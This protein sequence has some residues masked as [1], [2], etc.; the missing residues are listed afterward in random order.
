MSHNTG[1]ETAHLYWVLSEQGLWA[2]T[3]MKTC[4]N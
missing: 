1:P 3:M 4:W 2:L